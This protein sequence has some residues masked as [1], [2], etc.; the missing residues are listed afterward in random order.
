MRRHDTGQN[1]ANL[2]R[3]LLGENRGRWLHRLGTFGA[4]TKGCTATAIGKA[5]I[6]LH[7]IAQADARTAKSDGKPRRFAFRQLEINRRL[8]NSRGEPCWTDC[9]EQADG[10]HIQRHLQR[11]ADAD[12]ALIAHIEVT[13]TITRKILRAV[14]DDGFLRNQSLLEGQ[15]IDERF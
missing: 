4:V 5:C 8:S 11:L 10:R 9:I 3:C 14:L 12:I 13:R 7:Q 2:P 15:P 1:I 6:K